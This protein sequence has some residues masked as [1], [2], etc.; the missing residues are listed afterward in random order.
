MNKLSK[1]HFWQWFL[2]NNKEYLEL[3][4]KSKKESSYWLNELNAHLRAYYKFFEFCLSTDKNKTGTLTITV[5]GKSQYFKKV[6]A[7]VASAPDIPGWTIKSLEDPFPIDFM[8]ETQI[9]ETGVDP[10]E[11]SFQFDTD[12]P[13]GC[14]VVYHPMYTEKKKYSF[15]SLARNAIYNLLGERSFGIEIHDIE[16]LNLSEAYVDQVQMFENLPEY[17]NSLNS[18]ITVDKNGMLL[19]MK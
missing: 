6:D 5:D 3:S 7:M 1:N 11:L 18:S 2:R 9:E 4:K 16:V 14:L 10:R 17:I 13:K 15:Y 12:P 19:G 8:L